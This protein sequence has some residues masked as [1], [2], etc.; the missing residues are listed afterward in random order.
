MPNY[1]LSRRFTLICGS[2]VGA[3]AII[4]MSAWIIESRPLLQIYV[5][6]PPMAFNTALSFLLCVVSL[7]MVNTRPRWHAALPAA[8]AA[9]M[10]LV[11]L[12]E[13][14]A[15][16]NIGIDTLFVEP[17]VATKATYRGRMAINTAAAFVLCGS[18][19]ALCAFT[20]K[21]RMAHVVGIALLG[22][23]A[24]A[25]GLTA[26]VGELTGVNTANLWGQY[27]RM[28]VHTAFCFV[29][30]S[31]AILLFARSRSTGVP[32]WLAIP[33]FLA[34]TV[35]TF[36]IV[37][38]VRE[39]QHARLHQ[40]VETDARH[41]AWIVT[42]NLSN[43][44]K[45]L[46]RLARRWERHRP[47]QEE[48][49]R[50]AAAYAG[51]FPAIR[52]LHWADASGA[53]RWSASHD[54]LA[55]LTDQDLNAWPQIAATLDWA[56]G[57]RKPRVSMVIAGADE[58]AAA[59][60][61]F[62]HIR[63]IFID[64]RH[65]GAIVTLI[66]VAVLFSD[67]QAGM[68]LDRLWLRVSEN[69]RPIFTNAGA[70]AGG[71]T[72]AESV[73]LP[74]LERVWLI[75]ATPRPHLVAITNSAH[76]GI[77]AVVGMLIA[78]LLTCC[79]LLELERQGDHEALRI[80]EE[81]L[82]LAVSGTNDGLWDWNVVTD[83][84]Y[85]SP[86]VLAMLGSKDGEPFS[87]TA[88]FFAHVHRDDREM[89]KAAIQ[90]HFTTREP[91]NVTFRVPRRDGREV[92]LNSRGQAIWNADGRVTR[93]TGFMSDIS[94]EK[95]IERLKNEFVATVSH[96]LRTPLTSIR[97]ALA[98]I[99]GGV[100][101]ILPARVQE[102][103]NIAHNN[104]ERL[105]VLINDILDL[106]KIESGEVRFEIAEHPLNPLLQDAVEANRAFAIK[107]GVRLVVEPLA[108]EVCVKVDANRLNQVLNNLI[109]NAAKFSPA[110]MIVIVGAERRDG[111]VRV[112]VTDRGPGIPEEFRDRIFGKFAQAD[113]SPNRRQAGTGLGLHIS[114][115]I[116]KRLGGDIG[117]ETEKGKGTTFW[118]EL[119]VVIGAAAAAHDR[120][121]PA[122]SRD[123]APILICE[124]DPDAARVLQVML[125]Q[126]GFRSVIV[127][128]LAHARKWLTEAPFQ[129]LILDLL[130]PDGN[131]VDLIR[132]IRAG[133]S[134]DPLPIIVTSLK[135]E[136]QRTAINGGAIGVVDWL[137]KEIDPDELMAA[138][139]R[140]VAQSA[141]TPPRILHVEDD[142][143][144]RQV[145]AEFLLGKGTIVPAGTV[146]EGIERVAAER[147]DLIILDLTLSDGSGHALLERLGSLPSKPPVLI[148]SAQDA[149]AALRSRVAATLVKSRISERT[150][151][152]MITRLIGD[153]GQK[154]REAA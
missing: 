70:E 31:V 129:A 39:E 59:R 147:F 37:H 106:D 22:S 111:K 17:F 67:L 128:S 117:F 130:L 25:L 13:Y 133:E 75:A 126:E 53:I 61:A 138:L 65:D 15:G 100:L 71:Q 36:S 144:F 66:D 42:Q 151:V 5:N 116:I 64:G 48:W 11:T 43:T 58:P 102:M 92:W 99:R 84:V 93:M 109:S 110:D 3:I 101:G 34:L 105:I 19:L 24:G 136:E 107:D 50:D 154:G 35:V 123:G 95:E 18:A 91:F 122:P 74:N 77:I 82:A 115:Q 94:H 127:H 30:L 6:L 38:V 2:V 10:G 132:A 72:I 146:E 21:G 148:L 150:L 8:M 85:H 69:G 33:I 143:D 141:G 78:L 83:N 57:T 68:P 76:P 47:S 40:R 89:L 119:P 153:R 137:K 23:A 124:D 41:A 142:A 152:E 134:G 79:V 103:A 112:S 52:G 46:D 4:V 96:E 81:R 55:P 28:A 9:L 139:Q 16:V 108:G 20:A 51:D 56:V 7:A 86:R 60:G 97:G 27:T 113:A 131:G 12:I 90:H 145:I 49:G 125:Q 114:Q 1:D 121:T 73:L 26:L 140:C 104:C 87:S 80:S 45:A 54:T 44:Y 118:F 135:A 14:T 29:L 88:A 120:I 32:R 62:V 63:P 149:D 98:L